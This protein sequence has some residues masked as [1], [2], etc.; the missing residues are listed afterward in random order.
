MS[1]PPVTDPMSGPPGYGTPYSGPPGYGAPKPK[2]GVAM[3]LFAA[4]TVLFFLAAAV[5]SGL[6][7]TKSGAFDRKVNDLKARDTAISQRDSQISDLKAKVDSLQEQLDAATQKQSGT[8]N[9]LDEVTKEKQVIVNCI[10][11]LGEA[12]QAAQAGDKATHDAKM[13]QA[14]PVCDEAGRYLQ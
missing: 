2:R 4:L 8:Q 5:M 10:T 7:I 3:P 9:Q 6:Y 12:N 13:A 11:L 14:K 1:G